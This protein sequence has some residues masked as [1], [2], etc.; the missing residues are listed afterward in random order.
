MTEELRLIIAP[1]FSEGC[2][3]HEGQSHAG[4][5]WVRLNGHPGCCSPD[6]LHAT[7]ESA[8]A[9]FEGRS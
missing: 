5:R 2:F 8:L 9:C 7:P 1:H 6:H 3:T 4:M